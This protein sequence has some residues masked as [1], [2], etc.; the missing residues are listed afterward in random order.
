MTISVVIPYYNGSRFIGDAL[1]SVRAQSLAPL[2]IVV[3]DDG[4]LPA[5]ALALDREARD[6]VVVHLPRNRGVSV[7]RN[8]GV[9]HARGEWIAF[10]DCDDLWEPRKL[11]FQAA[12]AAAD[13]QCR[14]VHCGMRSLLPGGVVEVFPKGEV[15]F[16]DLLVF[17][18]P[19]F[20]SAAMMQRQALLECG[21]FDPTMRCCEDLDLFL[22][23]CFDGGRFLSV[24]EPLVTRRIQP[25]GLSRN[26]ET[27]YTA[28]VRTYRNFRPVFRDGKK[29]LG[30]LREV[31]VDM[32]LRA[33]YARDLGLL[34][35]M[36]RSAA[37]PDI[38]LTVLLARVAWR[39]LCNRLRRPTRAV[40]GRC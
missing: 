20:P 30:T 39:A 29:S 17:P 31:H 13:P 16:E 1:A 5:E 37:R 25:G 33:L 19:I 28:A 26:L 11:E 3:V 23:F 32:T 21:L 34:W 8:A 22:R 9:A 12:V 38:P 35:R 7:A 15:A 24:P 14:A 27:F 10:L 36:L 6:C 2:E 18:C 40:S 4:S